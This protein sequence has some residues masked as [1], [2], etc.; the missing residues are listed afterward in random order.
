MIKGPRL[1]LFYCII[2]FLLFFISYYK[3]VICHTREEWWFLFVPLI[4]GIIFLIIFLKK[5]FENK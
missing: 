4:A 1:Y 5:M 3:I 2:C